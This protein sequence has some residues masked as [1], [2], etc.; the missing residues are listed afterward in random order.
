MHL[1][2]CINVLILS[3]DLDPFKVM[4]PYTTSETISNSGVYIWIHDPKP[5]HTVLTS[6]TLSDSLV[7]IW[8]HLG[9]WIYSLRPSNIRGITL[10][11]PLIFSI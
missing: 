9:F 4:D 10:G 5:S 11:D 2:F 3:L 8:I 6:E 7:L 1:E